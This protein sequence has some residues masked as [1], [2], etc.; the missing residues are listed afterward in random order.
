MMDTG[1]QKKGLQNANPT[2]GQLV[3]NLSPTT[4]NQ[5]L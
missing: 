5:H 4:Q 3:R 2:Q 1:C